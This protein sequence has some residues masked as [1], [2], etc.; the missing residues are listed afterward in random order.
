M[1]LVKWSDEFSVGVFTMDSHHRK[2]FDLLNKLDDAMVAGK[3]ADI[4]GGIIKELL[5]YTRYHFGEEEKLMEKI[6]YSGIA[7]Q[8]NAHQRFISQIEEYQ[9][10][11]QEGLEAFLSS[12]VS[13]LLTDWLKN[14]IGG[15]DKKYQKEMNAAGV[16]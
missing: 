6:N 8:K 15:L 3:G 2:L 9:K 14:H 1:A 16:R 4:V 11:S 13:R 7:A 10:K 5:D 12:G